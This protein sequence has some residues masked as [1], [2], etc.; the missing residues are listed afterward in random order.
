MSEHD[1]P[2][3]LDAEGRY[4]YLVRE[5]VAQQTLWILKDAGG[6]ML[7]VADGEECIPVW[8][9]A[10]QAR[11]WADGDWSQGEPHAI[12]LK[13]WLDRWVKGMTEDG[14]CVAV[15]PLPDEAGVVEQPQ[16]FADSLLRRLAKQNPRK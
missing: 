10:E 9:S 7:L 3:S 16:D 6:S 12:P 13:T 14:L 2:L 4:A 15:F 1:D 8:P 11:A 5:A